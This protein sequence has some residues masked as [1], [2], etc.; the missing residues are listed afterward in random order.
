MENGKI[1]PQALNWSKKGFK[2]LGVFLGDTETESK[3]VE[4]MVLVV[5]SHVL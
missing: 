3:K 4:E 5:A 2:Y 1:W